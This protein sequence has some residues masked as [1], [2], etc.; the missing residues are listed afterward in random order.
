MKGIGPVKTALQS[1]LHTL[2][3]CALK[4]KL[5]IIVRHC[6]TQPRVLA[7]SKTKSPELI[8]EAY[9]AGQREFG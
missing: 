8:M 4:H 9:D 7:V 2:E 5:S 3:S 1:I 6:F